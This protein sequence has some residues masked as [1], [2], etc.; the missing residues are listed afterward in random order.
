MK[1]TVVLLPLILLLAFIL[2][3]QLAE[4]R[5]ADS[6]HSFK[7]DRTE[8]TVAHE[9]AQGVSQENKVREESAYEINKPQED[10]PSD[11]V[12]VFGVVRDQA[13]KPISGA[14]VKAL[15]G[16]ESDR[17]ADISTVTVKDGSYSLSGLHFSSGSLPVSSSCL[18]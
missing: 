4:L 13:K 10:H 12:D 8:K 2:W 6:I 18:R 1:R 3:W 17:G 11:E 15:Q 14:E 16:S 7:P 5:T 9:A